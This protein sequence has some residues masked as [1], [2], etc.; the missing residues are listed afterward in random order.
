MK[1]GHYELIHFCNPRHRMETQEVE[2][3]EQEPKERVNVK[4]LVTT[5]LHDLQSSQYY[6]K[7]FLKEV[8]VFIHGRQLIFDVRGCFFFSFF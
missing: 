4:M 7:E 5:R 2:D 8:L 1:A 6:L 3:V